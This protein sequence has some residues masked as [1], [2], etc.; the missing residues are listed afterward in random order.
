MIIRNETLKIFDSRALDQFL[1][2]E[3]KYFRALFGEYLKQSDEELKASFR[4]WIEHAK[5]YGIV[6][7]VQVE[8]YLR[9]CLL[10]DI[11]HEEPKQDDINN[12]LAWPG[13]SESVKLDNLEAYFIQ[14]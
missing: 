5:E 3:I 9:L 4:T 13:D 8:R 12:I 1:E 10:E 7:E 6:N 11:M 14:I 2:K